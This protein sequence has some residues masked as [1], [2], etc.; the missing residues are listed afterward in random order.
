MANSSDGMQKPFGVSRRQVLAGAAALGAS[1]AASGANAFPTAILSGRPATDVILASGAGKGTIILGVTQEATN[2]NPLLYVNT[3]VETIVE[4]AVFDSPWTINEKGEFIPNLAT[5][6]PSAENGGISA[7]GLEWTIKLREGVKWHDGQPFTAKDVVFTYNTIMNP[8]IAIRSRAGHDQVAEIS[9]PDDHTV[10][11]KLKQQFVPYLVAWQKT[12]IIPEHLLKDVPDM[13]TAEFNAK[14]I[15]TGPFKFKTRAAGDYIEYEPNT[16]YH[17]DGPHV[18]T[19]IQKFVPDQQVLFAQFQTGQVNIIDLQGIPPELYAR[20]K[21]LPG[22]HVF[23]SPSPFVEFIY[24]NCAKPQFTDKRVRQALYLAMDKEALI[25]KVYLGIPKRTLGYLPSE[26]WAYNS[27]LKDPGYDP[28]K[29]AAML[30]EA[31]WKVGADGIREK[32]GVKLAFTI[33]TTAG[34]KSRERGQQLFQQNLKQIGVDMTLNNM[35]ASVVWG[36]Y[37]VKSQFDTLMVAWDPL[38]YP[39]P[40]YSA[41]IGSTMIPAKGGSGANYV[42][43]E[44]KE[45]DALSAQGLVETNM[46]KRKEIYHKIHAILFEDL[47][48]APLFAYSTICANDVTV[49][50]YDVNS[51]HASNAWNCNTWSN[52]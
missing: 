30:D 46:D 25:S 26:H 28:E 6:I 48:M 50:G 41:R 8:K 4:V 29:A 40:D 21:A 12:S 37:T 33:S 17:G 45:V 5:E 36:D 9:A 24:F 2:F 32:D 16:E 42:Q 15:G 43:Y 20:A 13:N 10:K 22:K 1:A 11:I 38:L 39:D 23:P 18:A 27:T 44:N 52:G 7:D 19:Y 49:K 35:P 34:N 47:P 51:Y 31:G 3:G 14:P